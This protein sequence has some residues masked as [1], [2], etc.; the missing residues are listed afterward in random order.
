[1]PAKEYVSLS[2][3]TSKERIK[4]ILFT[5]SKNEEK[6]PYL[7]VSSF[8]IFLKPDLKVFN[9]YFQQTA[10]VNATEYSACF[11]HLTKRLP[12]FRAALQASGVSPK[13]IN[14]NIDI[15]EHFHDLRSLF[16]HAAELDQVKKWQ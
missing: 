10:S 5:D 6:T 16:E 11:Y 2:I 9:P 7:K 8:C 1:M 14:F 12:F 3:K 13:N 4:N 15:Y